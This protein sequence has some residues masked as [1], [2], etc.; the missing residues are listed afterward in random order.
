MKNILVFLVLSIISF[1]AFAKVDSKDYIFAVTENENGLYVYVNVLDH[2]NKYGSLI[3]SYRSEEEDN[4]IN[5]EMNKLN[6]CNSMESTFEPCR[7]AFS[8][9]EYVKALKANGFIHSLSFEQW[10]ETQL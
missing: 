10:M 9:E 5:D 6:L 4:F 8:K 2:W 1:S 7:Q 3:D